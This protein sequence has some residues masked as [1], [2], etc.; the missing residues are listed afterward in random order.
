[1]PQ[2]NVLIEVDATQ[3]DAFEASSWVASKIGRAH[4]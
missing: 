3:E 4:V 1:M 2:I